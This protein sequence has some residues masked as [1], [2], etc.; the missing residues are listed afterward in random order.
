MSTVALYKLCCQQSRDCNRQRMLRTC[1]KMEAFSRILRKCPHKPLQSGPESFSCSRTT[2]R[3]VCD[4]RIRAVV[5]LWVS[6]F[7]FGG[8]TGAPRQ[9]LG[10]PDLLEQRNNGLEKSYY[11]PHVPC[12]MSSLGQVPF[13]K[14]TTD[15]SSG[16]I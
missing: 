16:L 4:T 15:P 5:F 6:F 7:P 14:T 12:V 9:C 1:G 3:R 8:S 2:R 13:C 10:A 11:V